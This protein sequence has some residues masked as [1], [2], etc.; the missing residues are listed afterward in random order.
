M[1]GDIIKAN[2]VR[3]KWTQE[4]LAERLNVT[5]ATVSKWELHQSMPDIAML[6]AL[7]DAFGISMDELLEYGPEKKSAERVSYHATLPEKA[8]RFGEVYRKVAKT[9]GKVSVLNFTPVNLRRPLFV[10]WKFCETPLFF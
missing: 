1:I 7:G 8:F 9:R 5:K 4:Q 2:R 10:N 3:K 6:P